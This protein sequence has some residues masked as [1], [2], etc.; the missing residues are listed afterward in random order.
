VRSANSACPA[1]RPSWRPD[2]ARRRRRRSR[3]SISCR[4][5]FPTS[6]CGDKTACSSVATNWR[7]FAIPLARPIPF[8]FRV[9]QEDE[10]GADS[11]AG[12]RPLHRA[13]GRR[14]L[15][16]PTWDGESHLAQAICRAVI[17]QGYR[18]ICHE[19]HT[20]LEELADA[21]L[22][23]TRKTYLADLAAVPL[24]IIDDLGMRKLPHTAAEDLLEIIMRRYERA[25]T[26]LTSNRPVDDWGKLLGDTAQPPSPRSSIGCSITRT[27]SNADLGAWEDY[28]NY[29]GHTARS[30]G[31]PRTNG[32]WRKQER[33]RHRHPRNLQENCDFSF[34]RDSPTDR[35][36][37]RFREWVDASWRGGSEPAR[38]PRHRPLNR[39]SGLSSSSTRGFLQL[40]RRRSCSE[41]TAAHCGFPDPLFSRSRI[42]AIA[43]WVISSALSRSKSSRMTSS[44][45][46]FSS[47][48]CLPMCPK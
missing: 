19:A 35:R 44:H 28:Y 8:D 34:G 10:P 12:D 1:W 7:A 38:H 48:I 13:T 42:R 14:A 30:T 31:R 5:S 16:G 27:S 25:S 41:Q 15:S 22:D 23:D 21:T 32:W 20:R 36:S 4:C 29:H 24:L 47:G 17:Q 39:I 45:D 9:Q 18:V 2:Y 43:G 37:R 6:C 26:L 46:R 11:R 33:E 3:P 40:W